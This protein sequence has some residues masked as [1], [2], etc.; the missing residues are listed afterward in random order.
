MPRLGMFKQ[1]AVAFVGMVGHDGKAVIVVRRDIKVFFIVRR[2]LLDSNGALGA[3]N[4]DTQRIFQMIVY[5]MRGNFRGQSLR[6]TFQKIIM[7]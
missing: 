1:D 5:R 2:N 6:D 4:D 3:D 7:I